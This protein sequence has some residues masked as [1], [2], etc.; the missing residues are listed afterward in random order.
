MSENSAGPE[1]VRLP[2]IIHIE[3]EDIH[4]K[5][6][7]LTVDTS[8]TDTCLGQARFKQKPSWMSPYSRLVGKVMSFVL[9][10]TLLRCVGGHTRQLLRYKLWPP[11]FFSHS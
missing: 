11:V 3:E 1:P 8:D 2:G 7:M 10:P 6:N 9:P 5:L 4:C